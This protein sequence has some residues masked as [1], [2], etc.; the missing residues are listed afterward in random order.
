MHPLLQVVH[1]IREFHKLYS[2]SPRG[3]KVGACPFCGPT[4]FF[5]P[6]PGLGIRCGKCSAGAVQIAMGRA[7]KELAPDLDALSVCELSADGAIATYV[8]KHAK[9]VA[10]SEYFEGV[11]PGSMHG[12]VRCEDAQALTYPSNAFDLV[13]HTEVLEHV[14][15]DRRAFGELLRILRPGGRM[16][17]TVPMHDGDRTVERA[18]IENGQLVHLHEPVYHSDPLRAE[19]ILAYRDY[20]RDVIARVA[21]AGFAEARFHRSKRRTP[22]AHPLPVITAIKPT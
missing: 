6:A 16:I 17:F 19:G 18:R 15:D 4:M 7:L 2:E 3:A 10:L 11:A 9:S 5:E 22:Y 8:K 13:T 12:N 14:P 21:D 1:G 20:G